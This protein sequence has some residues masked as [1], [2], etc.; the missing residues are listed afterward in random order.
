M[1]KEYF[2]HLRRQFHT[3][4]GGKKRRFED[5]LFPANPWD[6]VEETEESTRQELRSYQR[7]EKSEALQSLK[8]FVA[9]EGEE[10]LGEGRKVQFSGGEI[11][12]KLNPEDPPYKIAETAPSLEKNKVLVLALGELLAKDEDPAKV[13]EVNLMLTKMLSAM[14]LTTD[15][16]VRKPS[17]RYYVNDEETEKSQL[18]VDRMMS[19]I[20]RHQVKYV[21]AF[22]A[23]EARCLLGKRVRLASIHGKMLARTIQYDDGTEYT[24]TVV[25][26][27]HPE[28]LRVN[29]QMRQTTW[30]DLQQVMTQLGKA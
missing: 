25:P 24:F 1:I 20:Y 26:V 28:Y 3:A 16:V 14:K 9:N 30:S 5:E 23:L 22:G 29:P 27:F 2:E 18:V 8:T 7:D 4:T 10:A 15:E 13:E 12:Q 11:V 17:L 21:L 19:F 6:G